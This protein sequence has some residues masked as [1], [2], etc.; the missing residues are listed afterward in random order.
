MIGNHFRGLGTVIIEVDKNKK[1]RYNKVK[2]NDN[3]SIEC[4]NNKSIWRSPNFLVSKIQN[5]VKN[6]WLFSEPVNQLGSY[7][8]NWKII[9]QV[10][11]ALQNSKILL[12]KLE[13]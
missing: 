10:Q 11:N 2:E 3:N 12:K 4:G 9:L 5:W 8:T 7:T 1:C 13:N 6:S